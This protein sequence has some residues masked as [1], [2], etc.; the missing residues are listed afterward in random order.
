MAAVE[1]CL[2]E[3]GRT[4]HLS[5]TLLLHQSKLL[6]GDIVQIEHRNILEQVLLRFLQDVIS[7]EVPKVKANFEELRRPLAIHHNVC[8]LDEIL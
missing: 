3:V 1:K 8:H 5:C 7:K 2:H 4:T 6:G